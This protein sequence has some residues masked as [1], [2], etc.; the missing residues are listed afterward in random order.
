MDERASN[1]VVVDLE[2]DANVAGQSV[3]VLVYDLSMDGCMIDTGGEQLPDRNA[4]VDLSFP[5]DLLITGTLAWAHGGVGGIKFK[6]RLHQAVVEHLGFKPK[7]EF[8]QEFPDRFERPL[9][10]RGQAS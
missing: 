9:S 2:L 8:V 6:E 3:R 10:P 4:A 7:S 5:H 1:R